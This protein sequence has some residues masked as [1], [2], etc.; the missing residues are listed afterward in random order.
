MYKQQLLEA[1][2]RSGSDLAHVGK[3]GLGP[4][5]ASAGRVVATVTVRN[6]ACGDQVRFDLAARE[7]AA[8]VGEGRWRVEAA[9]HDPRGCVVCQASSQLLRE[10]AVGMELRELSGAVEAAGPVLDGAA[11]GGGGSASFASFRLFHDC[12]AVGSGRRHCAILPLEAAAQAA[13]RALESVYEQD[14]S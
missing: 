12:G 3:E 1:A 5:G 13:A 6:P 8:G 10:A 11:A 14:P 7:V 9:W 4:A 2:R